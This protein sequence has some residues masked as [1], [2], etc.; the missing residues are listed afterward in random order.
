M[1]PKS[2]AVFCAAS[3]DIAPHYAECAR[4]VGALIV[5]Q[6]CELVYGG[7]SAGLMEVVASV[8]K[9][10]NGHVVG[11]VPEILEQRN[12]V[13]RLICE[14]KRTQNL[15]DRKDYMLGRSDIFIALPGGIGTLDEVFHVMAAATIGYHNK[16]VIFYNIDGFWNSII[17][18]LKEFEQKGF[19]RRQ[20]QE[21]FIVADSL[22]ELKKILEKQV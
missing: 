22:V 15:S 12:R 5:R 21:L 18:M 16:K 1:K 3:E 7:A 6:G 2:I 19:V 20:S 9:E 10:N 11:V 13:S 17:A 14:K 8:V 4:E